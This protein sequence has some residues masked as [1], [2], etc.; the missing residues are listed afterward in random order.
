M[1]Q[2]EGSVKVASICMCSRDNKKENVEK[3]FSYLR[4]ASKE[5]ADWALLPEIFAFNGSYEDYHEMAE[6]GEGS[7]LMQDLCA[8]SKELNMV[9]FAGTLGERS[10][11]RD[12]SIKNHKGQRR[13]Y[14][15]LYVI[16]RDGAIIGKYR[17]THLFNLYDEKGKPLYCE[18]DG[19]LQGD[20]LA[21]VDV[22]GFS[23]GLSI[24]Y[25]LRF[26]ELYHKLQGLEEKPMDVIMVP[27]AFTKKTGEAHWELLLR[28][29]AAE[30]Q[31]FVVAA[32]QVGVHGPNRETYGHSMVVDPWG[33]VLCN[34]LDE[35]G[36]AYGIVSKEKLFDVRSRLPVLKNRRPELYQ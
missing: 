32:N 4:E 27:S 10:G 20:S 13:V 24:C 16:G 23:V 19:F 17:K 11:D 1:V 33:E 18:S 15:T 35:E 7:K 5:G 34:T 9:I 22:D 21:R 25:D 29:R 3:A 8:L 2:R 30:F 31:S 14:N 6:E 12:E 36:I 26:S 28:A